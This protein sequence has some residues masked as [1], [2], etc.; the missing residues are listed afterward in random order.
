MGRHV[1]LFAV[2]SAVAIL[3]P[4]ACP[5]LPVDQ[6]L[7]LR[8][9]LG[10]DPRVTALVAE[11]NSQ[12]HAG[13]VVELV[14]T[15]N[16]AAHS[17]AS[18]SFMLTQADG[19]VHLLKAPNSDAGLLQDAAGARLRVLCRVCKPA[20]GGGDLF[21]PLAIALDSEVT[22][23]ERAAAARLQAAQAT[24]VQR[25]RPASRS[26]SARPMA[27]ASV[28]ISDLARRYLTPAAQSVYGAYAAFI[29]NWNR[30]L[31]PTEVDQI[32]VSILYFANRHRVDPRLIVALIIAESDFNPRSTSHKGAMGLGQ[33]MPDEARAYRL[34]DPYDPVQNVRTSVNLLKLKLEMY[35]EPGMPA[36]ML[37]WRQI[38]LALAAYNAGGGAVRRYGGVPPYRETQGYV[39]R[40]KSLYAQ[41]C[42]AR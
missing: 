17:D 26:L 10:F 40:V 6:Y 22:A 4:A 7:R 1:R 13:R 21:E 18:T 24:T 37:S 36:D 5:G 42:G 8:R 14:G 29:A 2:L 3:L 41:L 32:A 15:L 28:P 16:G 34:T 23:R 30:R 39:R 9:Q 38:E 25:G 31:T 35:R 27:G 33:L 12:A 20:A 11:A 19:R